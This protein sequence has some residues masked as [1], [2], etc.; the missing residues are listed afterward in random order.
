VVA[1]QD[2]RVPE[3]HPSNFVVM[4]TTRRSR[5]GTNVDSYADC[6][7]TASIAG[8]IMTAGTPSY[9]NITLGNT[10]FGVNVP[11]GMTVVAQ[12]SG[13]VGGSG[14]YQLSGTATLSGIYATGVMNVLQSTEV[15]VQ[16][17]VHSNLMTTASDMAQRISTLFR[18]EYAVHFF[19]ASGFDVAPLYA[20][21]PKQMPFWND[22]SQIETR[23]II[24]AVM[25]ANQIVMNIPQQF[26][27]KVVIDPLIPVDVFYPL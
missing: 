10:L 3:P 14:T 23:W 18:D 8:N 25:Q 24:E 7:F 27:D 1:G 9:G 11:A 13:S 15:T 20:D 16:L 5:L 26:A 4:T 22:Q 19:K 17:D 12:L 21:E 2:N 6:V